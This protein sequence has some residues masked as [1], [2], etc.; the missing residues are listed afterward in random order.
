V[1]LRTDEA[2]S[3]IRKSLSDERLAKYYEAAG[4]D[5]AGALCLYER[6]TRLSET[7]YTPLQCM[8]I[9]LR[10]TLYRC[11]AEKYGPEWLQRD[12]VPLGADAIGAIRQA[13]HSLL[14]SNK[15]LTPGALVAELHFGFWVAI[16]GPR[17]DANLWRAALCNAFLDS[18]RRMRRDK[19]HGRFNAIRRFR[20]RVAHHEPIFQNDLVQ[21]HNEIIEATAWMCQHTAAWALTMSRFAA[22]YY[23]AQL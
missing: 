18:G 9:C 14:L 11:M 5:V 15:S 12:G 2:N 4:N 20:N 7:F 8:E 21:R 1:N 19:V 6:N 23:S 13:E 3:A 16:L 17:Y 22:V 10:N